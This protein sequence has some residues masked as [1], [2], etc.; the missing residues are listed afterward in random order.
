VKETQS[1]T[2]LCFTLLFCFP[3]RQ[4]QQEEVAALHEEEGDEDEEEDEVSNCALCTI[5]N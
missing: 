3:N 4:E 5:V 1:L 2:T